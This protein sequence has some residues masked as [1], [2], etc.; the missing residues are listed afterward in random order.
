[1]VSFFRKKKKSAEGKKDEEDRKN[2]R[3]GQ[4]ATTV[5]PNQTQPAMVAVEANAPVTTSTISSM[6]SSTAA[7][8]KSAATRTTKRSTSL[9]NRKRNTLAGS[10]RGSRS[11]VSRLPAVQEEH[12]HTI[13]NAVTSSGKLENE[14]LP[15]TGTKSETG[16]ST[17]ATIPSSTPDLLGSLSF[18]DHEEGQVEVLTP[19][20]KDQVRKQLQFE[21]PPRGSRVASME[22]S[23]DGIVSQISQ[24]EDADILLGETTLSTLPQDRQQTE[25]DAGAEKAESQRIQRPQADTDDQLTPTNSQRSSLAPPPRSSPNFIKIKSLDDEEEHVEYQDDEDFGVEDDEEEEDETVEPIS[26]EGP[27]IAAA[28]HAS[29]AAVSPNS[30]EEEEDVPEA[31]EPQPGSEV[32]PTRTISLEQNRLNLVSPLTMNPTPKQQSHQQQRQAHSPVDLDAEEEEDTLEET[33]EDTLTDTL[34]GNTYESRNDWTKTYDENNPIHKMERKLQQVASSLLNTLQCTPEQ[35]QKVTENPIEGTMS[36]FY[37]GMCKAED[38]D[39]NPRRPYFN[40]EFAQRFVKRM[41]T[42]GMSLLYLQPPNTASNPSDDWKGRTVVMKIVPGSTGDQEAIQ[43]KLQWTTMPG[44]TVT[45]AYMTS[46]S[47]LRIH[48][49][50]TATQNLVPEES[51]TAD[52]DDDELCFVSITSAAGKVFLFEANSVG[53]RDEI[54]NGLRNVIARLSFHLVAGD[55]QASTELYNDDRAIQE[56]AEPGDLP[57]L[58]NPKLNMNRMTHLLLEA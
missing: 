10:L 22:V 19:G 43:P 24:D 18:D 25:N 5:T 3:A 46:I 39:E 2:S 44:G 40:E 36:M 47:L 49:V 53:E 13:T 54:A 27:E 16:V 17:P 32:P 8:G 29:V 11:S 1:M 9:P 33:A 23:P 26:S 41:L 28:P 6:P 38:M 42:N 7:S 20:A 21:T 34:A 48:S 15:G 56:A 50:L 4:P 51:T 58:A 12:T 52:L 14:Q 55:H 35:V 30:Y 57:A 31:S 37:D 45:K